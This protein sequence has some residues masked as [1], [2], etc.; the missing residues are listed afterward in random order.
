M[1]KAASTQ[2][3]VAA[4]GCQPAGAG[5]GARTS[6]PIRGSRR[7]PT[8]PIAAVAAHDRSVNPTT[9]DFLRRRASD[10]APSTGIVTMTRSEPTELAA[11]YIVF[12]A[13]RSPTSHT[14]KYSV[15]TFIEKIVLEKSYNAQLHRSRAGARRWITRAR[16]GRPRLGCCSDVIL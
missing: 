2:N 10:N 9:H 15:A 11:A 5:C 12:D 4:F 1:A 7:S 6:V 8:T 13:P 3:N 16:V 14:E